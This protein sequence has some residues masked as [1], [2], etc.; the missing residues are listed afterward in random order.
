MKKQIKKRNKKYLLHICLLIAVFILSLSLAAC[1]DDTKSADGDYDDDL[2]ET[3]GDADFSEAEEDADLDDEIEDE[4][5]VEEE[6]ESCNSATPCFVAYYN[7]ETEECEQNPYCD[8]DNRNVCVSDTDP[9]RCLCDEGFGTDDGQCVSGAVSGKNCN[10]AVL[11]VPD[12]EIHGDPQGAEDHF[13]G[14]CRNVAGNE[15]VYYFYVAENVDAEFWARGYDSTLYLRNV[16]SDKNSETACNDDTSTDKTSYLDVNLEPGWHFLF[17]DN[18]LEKHKRYYLKSSFHCDEG[19]SFDTVSGKCEIDPCLNDPCTQNFRDICKRVDDENYE[20]LCSYGFV[21]SEG[22]CVPDTES[23]GINCTSPIFLTEMEG[24][25]TGTTTTALPDEKP[26]C[27]EGSGTSGDIVYMFEVERRSLFEIN[28][29]GG[30]GLIYLR[31]DCTD[32]DSEIMCD[33]GS[34]EYFEIN[35]SIELDAG[36]YYLFVDSYVLGDDFTFDYAIR[37]DPCK[38]VDCEG[39][40]YCQRSVDWSDYVCGCD[41]GKTPFNGNC[42]DDP[43]DPNPCTD[44]EHKNVCEL[45]YGETLGTECKCNYGFVDNEGACI[46]DPDANKWGIFIYLNADNNLEQYGYD[47]LEEM[48][49]AGSTKDVHIVVLFDSRT[50]NEGNTRKVYITSEGV[51]VLENEGE[52]DLGNWETLADFGI[53]A[54][55]NFPAQKTALIMWDHG[56]GWSKSNNSDSVFKSFSEDDHGS[57]DGISIAN[58]DYSKAL[59]AIT[60]FKGSKLDVIG[61][62]ACFM[63]MLEVAIASKDYGDIFIGSQETIPG[64]GWS[65]DDLLIPLVN[66]PD[67]TPVEFATNIV[68]TYHDESEDNST[69]A[70]YD[71][72]KIDSVLTALSAFGDTLRNNSDEYETIENHRLE[73]QNVYLYAVYRDLKDFVER[74][75]NDL[76]LSEELQNSAASLE[77]ALDEFIVFSKHQSSHPNANG[78]NLYIPKH[79]TWTSSKYIKENSPWKD[80]FSW[81]EFLL[82]FAGAVESAE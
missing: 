64:D 73:S 18:M 23:S 52:M 7:V 80:L 9:P 13:R 74:V 72:S 76:S 70:V 36:V 8:G 35:H 21:E 39:D 40:T 55:D 28:Y 60:D 71:L 59:K 5:E 22:E 3:D 79:N 61:F 43:C 46:P 31:T 56:N 2:A 17:I 67:T 78:M 62:D 75:K 11:L 30:E 27:A 10:D 66:N 42:V 69:L 81:D 41:E 26:S 15:N 53:W 16:C 1:G 45:V 19:K 38:D 25:V 14:S 65:Y 82:D 33:N 6:K 50:K 48:V 20:C 51:E 24:T 4:E 47:D 54:V 68:Q 57:E 32:P 29:E 44:V 63:G 34:S 12:I 37:P 49:L 58:G 77:L